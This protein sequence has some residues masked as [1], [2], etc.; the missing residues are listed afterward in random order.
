MSDYAIFLDRDDTLITDIGYISSPD[1]VKL[2]DGAAEALI[3]FKKMG[4]KLIVVS[5]QSGVARGYFSEETLQKIHE[6]MEQLLR[7]KGAYLDKIYYC[8]YLA[9]A[10]IEKY[11]IDSEDR[12]PKPGMLL[13]A[14]KELDIDLAKSW[15]IGDTQRDIDAGIAAGCKT[16]LIRHSS[17]TITLNK[18]I[19]TNANHIAV[20]IREAVNIVKKFKKEPT[21]PAT[22]IE[23][24]PL[25]QTVVPKNEIQNSR[26]IKTGAESK[27]EPTIEQK[28]NDANIPH[29]APKPQSTEISNLVSQQN[30]TGN[31]LN[32][33]LNELK[34]LRRT[35]MFGDFSIMRLLAGLVQIIVLLCLLISVWI[36][37]NPTKPDNHNSVFVMLGF[38][39]VLQIMA[40]TFYVQSRK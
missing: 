31:V 18:D 40:L 29:H 4:F 5:N 34:A 10:A 14:A 26:Q 27:M 6:R 24:K 36:L 32:D 3:E 33:I 28:T 30:D 7:Q 12:K 37:M 19:S 2:I 20:N 17:Q 25:E 15:M 21:A 13:K 35:D 38:A 8:P 1:Q 11:R 9:D 39:C 22:P 16:I 23:L